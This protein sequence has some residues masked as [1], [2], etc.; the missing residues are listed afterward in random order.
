MASFFSYHRPAASLLFISTHFG[1]TPNA[2]Q[3]GFLRANAIGFSIGA[4][5]NLPPISGA[6]FRA[7]ARGLVRG[8]GCVSIY[9]PFAVILFAV[10]RVR[11]RQPGGVLIALL[12][13]AFAC[14]GL[15]IHRRWSLALGRN[16]AAIAGMA[17]GRSGGT[18]QMVAGRTHDRHPLSFFFDGT[19]LANW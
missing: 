11:H 4:P 2:I 13:I 16:T 10:N 18:L 7:M 1:L 14:L 15:V 17:S 6:R 9:A 3:S 19:A 8:G 12:F 5:R